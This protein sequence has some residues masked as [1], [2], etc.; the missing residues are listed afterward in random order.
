MASARVNPATEAYPVQL[1]SMLGP[2]YAVKNFARSGATLWHG[3]K[4]NAFEQL[5]AVKE[6]AP[7]I[8]VVMFGINDTRNE[9][10]DYWTHFDEFESEGARLLDALLAGAPSPRILLCLPTPGVPDLPGLTAERRTVLSE[11]IPRLSTCHPARS[12]G[13]PCA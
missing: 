11:R 13:C 10:V 6:F 9:G 3:G 8:A 1:Q 7:Q 4:A 5:P 12:R 2:G